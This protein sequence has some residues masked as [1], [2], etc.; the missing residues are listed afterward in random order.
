MKNHTRSLRSMRLTLD[1]SGQAM[2]EMAIILPILLILVFGII[3]MALAWRTS[4]IVT[5]VTREGAR[6]AVLPSADD[7][8]VEDRI[9]ALLN[10]SGFP[11]DDSVE[12]FQISLGCNPDDDP[13]SMICTTTGNE[14]QVQTDY[15]Y[16]FRLLGPLVELAGGGGSEFGQITISSTSRMRKE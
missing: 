5:N 14:T 12:G 15:P 1:S 2:A 11:T 10:A 13:D 7:G 16:Q 3:E 8:Q 6:L 9:T 4:Q